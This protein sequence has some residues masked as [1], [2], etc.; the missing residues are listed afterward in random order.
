MHYHI[1][2]IIMKKKLLFII[3]VMTLLTVLAAPLGASAATKY[4]ADERHMAQIMEREA[5]KTNVAARNAVGTVIMNRLENPVWGDDTISEVLLHKGQFGMTNFKKLE[6]I[7]PSKESLELARAIIKGKRTVPKGVEM[8]NNSPGKKK[9][10]L[11]MWGSHVYYKKI[12]GNYFFFRD[13]TSYLKWKKS[14][15]DG[16]DSVFYIVKKGDTLSRIAK[17]KKTSATTIKKLNNLSSSKIRIGQVIQVKYFQGTDDGKVCTYHVVQKNEKL[18]NI[19]KFYGVSASKIK[20]NNS[21]KSSTLKAGTRLLIRTTK[22]KYT[23]PKA[24]T[25]KVYYTVKSGDCLYNIAKKYRTTVAKIQS[26]NGMKNYNIYPGQK[27]RVK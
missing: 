16:K 9:N 11:Y 8:F 24:T 17:A 7:K 4:T 10:G 14:G 2:R 13:K 19:A 21:L 20:S 22:S 12:G 6:K 18:A 15:G 25:T 23:P 26:L 5:G 27:L 3:A 1:E